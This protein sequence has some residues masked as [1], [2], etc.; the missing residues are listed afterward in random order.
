MKNLTIL[1]LL[2]S[3][4]A[5]ATE[6]KYKAILNTWVGFSEVDLIRKWGAPVNSYESGDRKFIV[7]SSSRNVVLPGTNPTYTT[8]VI[9]NTAYTNTY[10]GTPARNIS[11]SC[12][13]TFELKNKTIVSWSFRGNN[14][15]SR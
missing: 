6:G 9:G 12:E 4:V 3:V 15:R 7:Y 2:F 8:N 5:C 1:I 14:C 13:T 11:M 10:G